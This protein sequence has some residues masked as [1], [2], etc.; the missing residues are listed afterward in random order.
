VPATLTVPRLGVGSPGGLIA[1]WY[2]P[3]GSTV[4]PG[5]RVF[6]LESGFVSIDIEAESG[7]VVRH[8]VPA[9]IPQFEGE[10]VGYVL[11]PGERMPATVDTDAE[12]SDFVDEPEV[13]AI[14]DASM[15]ASFLGTSPVGAFG[16]ELTLPT[17]KRRD[18]DE[19][20]VLLRPR[21]KLGEPEDG[22]PGLWELVTDEKE[23]GV[24]PAPIVQQVVVAAP[25]R[26]RPLVMRVA[27]PMTEAAKI[28]E[29]LAGEWKD[30]DL[31]V[32]DEATIVRAVGH[33]AQE[34]LS[35]KSL[36]DN[37]ALVSLTGE[38]PVWCSV[39]HPGKGP[40]KDVVRATAAIVEDDPARPV[41]VVSYTAFGID[42]AE[43]RL[44]DGAAIAVGFARPVVTTAATLTL[45]YDPQ[46]VD[47][48]VAAAFLGRVRE[49][50]VQPYALLA[51]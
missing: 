26:P 30:E 8:A 46:Q 25:A 6:R 11:G 2:A 43:P 29:Q 13:D 33:A 1:E 31:E 15:A 9:G 38:G 50:L 27:V 12:A 34:Q 35:L 41:T 36:A 40:F 28:R 39:E 24:A 5:D 44:A 42:S 21:G 47:D 10:A 45:V 22:R 3:E 16:E 23:P 4:E 48:H 20:P 51:E 19:E 14:G 32:R 7:G 49:L 17:A 18:P 37:I